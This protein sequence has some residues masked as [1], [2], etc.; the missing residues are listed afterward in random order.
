MQYGNSFFWSF[1]KKKRKFK[2]Y[3]VVWKPM[4]KDE[5]TEIIGFGLNRTMQ[6]G[7]QKERQEEWVSFEFKSYY[8]V[9]KLPCFAFPSNPMI[10]F[11]SYYVVWKHKDSMQVRGFD[12][13]V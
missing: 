7:N 4:V 2:S 5:R 12:R 11:K 3:Y 13:R 9:W 10:S 6:Y 8:V 1:F